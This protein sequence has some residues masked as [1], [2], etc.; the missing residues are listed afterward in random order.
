MIRAVLI[1]LLM[2]S[3]THSFSQNMEPL[4]YDKNWKTTNKENA[5]YYRIMPSKKLG[6]LVL[7][8]D[9]YTNKT[10]Q[11]QGYSFENNE[12]NY[13]GDI[14][15]YDANGFNQSFYQY[16]NRTNIPVLVYYYPNGKKRKTVAYKNGRKDG[17][18]IL[19]HEDGT[20]L[21]KG[22]YVKGRPEE[23]DF[24]E[25]YQWDNYRSNK[26][27]EEEIKENVAVTVSPLMVEDEV[28]V[29]NVTAEKE[30]PKKIVKQKIFWIN[31]KQ[32]AQEIWYNA[33]YSRF[34]PIRQINYDQSGKVLQ[35][36]KNGD[37]ENYGRD[38][39]NGI[40]YTY[41]LQ[42]NFA[43]AIKS[44][45]RYR[46]GMKS[47]DE[48]KY[49]P[50]GKMVEIT[51]FLDDEIKQT[52]LSNSNQN[53]DVKMR[54]FKNGEP[55]DGNFDQNL[56]G[57]LSVNQNYEK[58]IKVGEAVVK[59]ENDT[60]VAKGTYKNG[61]PFNGTF[62]LKSDN[63]IYE[64]VNL[65]NFKKNGLQKVFGYDITNIIRTYECS[66]DVVNGLTTFYEDGKVIGKVAYK[67]GIPYDGNL[68][69]S[70]KNTFYEK[71]RITKVTFYRDK[72]ERMSEDNILK[73]VYY[74]NEKKVKIE[75]H[76][77]LILS[78][79]QDFYIGIFQNDKPY[80]GYFT[81]DFREFN[82]VD[83]YEK[84]EKQY[85][86]SNDYLKNL[87]KYRY[88][89][90]D[91]KST[92]KNGKIIDGPE[93]IQL[94]KQFV[95]K[96][97][98]NGVLESFDC[99][100]FAMH[101]FNRVHFELK[102]NSIEITEFDKNLKAKIT[103]DNQISELIINGKKVMTS[104]FSEVKTTIPEVAGRILYIEKDNKIFEKVINAV[105]N[106]FEERQTIDVFYQIFGSKFDNTKTI[107]ENFNAL[108][109]EFSKGNG[110]KGLFE[111]QEREQTNW[112]A[113]LGFTEAKKP[114]IGILILKNKKKTYDL[115]AFYNSKVIAEN[116]EV[117][118]ENIRKE[119]NKLITAIENKMRTERN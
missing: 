24:E 36:L 49:A 52:A 96:Y 71:G 101:Y 119:V 32:L 77:F 16:Y 85:Q 26:S 3:V 109:E 4:Y 75:D 70:N 112:I 62:V 48:S 58:G 115:K 89:N 93:Y 63:N 106:D 34:Q 41:Y 50:D 35:T 98:K 61:A 30:L 2:F 6:N 31:S 39:A 92:Y 68:V 21:M 33:E 10:P 91:L 59:T 18:T 117:T 72:Y 37:F 14:M 7:L 19:F 15:W 42:N 55:Y 22:K 102:N 95:S 86:Y 44:T 11:F 94:D 12:G 103:S 66:N 40:S 84:G 25:V 69:E 74:E 73:I 79:R 17:E 5:S 9:F 88:P 83:Y 105:Q 80:S 60:I 1:T 46:D 47:G 54:T 45:T 28:F 38:I 104:S 110:I 64:V 65:I 82:Y 87:E 81:T 99:D 20:V 27:D 97:W 111:H 13:A 8:E 29:G 56:T 100:L 90:Y 57:S 43:V 116:K 108:A 67:N 51:R 23:G 114:E 107:A 113:T 118:I 78:D 76:S 53:P